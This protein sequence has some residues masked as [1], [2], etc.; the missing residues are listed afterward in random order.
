MFYEGIHY[1]TVGHGC[2]KDD[3]IADDWATHVGASGLLFNET[4]GSFAAISVSDT[5]MS[6]Q[7]IDEDGNQIHKADLGGPQKVQ[8]PTP[9]HSDTLNF[10][11]Y[12]ML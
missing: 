1:I 10:F 9:K 8:P 3:P 11:F 4:I 6:V 7:I 2:D 5:Q 12:G